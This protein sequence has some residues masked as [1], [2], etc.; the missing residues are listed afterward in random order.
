MPETPKGL[1]TIAFLKTRLD[2]GHDHVSMFEPLVH[3]ALHGLTAQDFLADDIQLQVGNRSSIR[4]PRAAVSTLLRRLTRRGF[5][6]RKGGRFFRTTKAIPKPDFDQAVE[7]IS[8]EQRALGAALVDY[9]TDKEFD[10][11]SAEAALEALATFVSDNKVQ[12]VLDETFRDSPL[13]RSSGSRKIVRL[14][15][16]FI[17]ERCLDP[18]EHQPAFKALIEGIVLYDTVLLTE[19]PRATER[20]HALTVILDTP[21]LFSA[22]GLHGTA[23]SLAANEGITMLREAG[24]RTIAFEATVQEMRGV[25][26]AYEDRVATTEGRL[27]LRPTPLAHYVLTSRLSSADLRIISATLEKRVQDAGVKIRDFPPRQSRYTLGEQELATKLLDQDQEDTTQPRIRHD[28]DCIAGVLTLRAGRTSTSI[29]RAGAIFCTSSGRVVRNVQKWF[30]DEGQ[31]G[32]PPIIHQEALTSIAWL[33]TPGTSPLKIHELAAVCAAAMR[34]TSQTWTKFVDALR[35]LRSDGSI[36]DDETVAIVVSELTE[37][38]LAH[39]DDDG[40]VDA[41]SIG[42]AVERIRDRYRTEASSVAD[43]VRRRSKVEV[44]MA[45]RAANDAMARAAQL[46]DVI[47]ANVR[48]NSRTLANVGLAFTLAL[49]IANVAL[50]FGVVD[51]PSATWVGRVVLLVAA[52]ASL[53]SKIAGHSLMDMR[54]S[55]QEWI[56][57]KLRRRWLPPTPIAGKDYVLWNPHKIDDEPETAQPESQIARRPDA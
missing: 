34:P 13:D 5:L 39:L 17:T 3:D 43:G 27:R 56:T 46:R 24:A 45:E 18:S 38:L 6:V 2:E 20:F 36:T 33:K 4:L 23:N 32:I 42:E 21:V 35:R 9:A 22:L 7:R 10:F 54:N 40:D 19:L 44:A 47:D 26:A 41:N 29:E 16:R 8:V 31:D 15:A 49:A 30:V 1:A 12:L 48:R 11:G 14:I 50:A 28:V 55:C 25:L 51:Y 37:P 53:Y 52:G 57:S